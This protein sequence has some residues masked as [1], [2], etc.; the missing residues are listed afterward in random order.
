MK[1]LL[2][3]FIIY[4]H[5]LARAI[6]PHIARQPEIT[7]EKLL[8]S[9]DTELTPN[10][11]VCADNIVGIPTTD[12]SRD[13]VCVILN[14]YPAPVLAREQARE[15]GI[16]N[17]FVPNFSATN[18]DE[19]NAPLINT[20]IESIQLH[21]R[22]LTEQGIQDVENYYYQA[23]G[24]LANV[25]CGWD[26]A[27]LNAF[28]RIPLEICSGS[29]S[30]CAR[31]LRFYTAPTELLSASRYIVEHSTNT[32]TRNLNPL[33]NNLEHSLPQTNLEYDFPVTGLIEIRRAFLEALLQAPE[34]FALGLVKNEIQHELGH[35]C[36]FIQSQLTAI[37]PAQNFSNVG[38]YMLSNRR[39]Q[40]SR[41][42]LSCAITSEIHSHYHQL[43][44]ASLDRL[45]AIN[46]NNN[47]T[48]ANQL[49]SCLEEAALQISHDGLLRSCRNTCSAASMEESFAMAFSFLSQETSLYDHSVIYCGATR[50]NVHPLAIDIIECLLQH[51]EPFRKRM[52]QD[53]DCS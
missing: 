7:L 32:N 41:S 36:S 45:D 18:L 51:V 34:A 42:E 11:F 9:F 2:L 47:H 15:L 50:S 3:A 26:Q 28:N 16:C 20:Q 10:T 37:S 44:A 53:F 24:R 8:V 23:R 17:H 13:D 4:T 40:T 12:T 33:I 52:K 39:G 25:C 21:N 49:T 31:T 14:S 19:C 5:N 29:I 43:L 22:P 38:I 46:V 27:C 6:V 30:E 48:I 35:A 1:L